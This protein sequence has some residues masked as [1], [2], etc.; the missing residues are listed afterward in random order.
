ML[1]EYNL[2]SSCTSTHPQICYHNYCEK[3]C[4][5]SFSPCLTMKFL[6]KYVYFYLLYKQWQGGYPDNSPTS[7][8][9][10]SCD[11][12]WQNSE[13]WLNYS[14]TGIPMT[15]GSHLACNCCSRSVNAPHTCMSSCHVCQLCECLNKHT[16]LDAYI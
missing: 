15:L 12:A 13:V 9:A 4:R 6:R 7:L 14:P 5:C 2:A 10:Q 16:S 1:F 8:C 3:S 11:S